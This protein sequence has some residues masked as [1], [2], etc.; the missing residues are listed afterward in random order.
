MR[1]SG[2]LSKPALGLQEKHVP[3]KMSSRRFSQPWFNRTVKRATGRNKRSFWKAIRINKT[4]DYERYYR[5]KKELWIACKSAYNS[6]IKNIISPDSTSNPKRFWG[7]IKGMRTDATGVAPLKDSIGLTHLDSNK[8]ANILYEQFSSVFN[9]D[10]SIDTI[11]GKG[12]S[13]Y[14]DMP[15]ISVGREGRRKL[16][17]NPQI[18]QATGPDGVT[19][20][21]K[22][23]LCSNIMAHVERNNL[24]HD[25]QHGF[26]KRRSRESQLIVTFKDLAH[27]IDTKGQTDVIL[28]DFSKAFDKAPTNVFCTSSTT[29]G[30][31]T[32]DG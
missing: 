28:L 4:K 5:L 9:K 15:H 13:P 6:N 7:F 2:V 22:H 29:T 24:L 27:N 14:M 10:E 26:R 23:I 1:R 21:L 17:S 19:C 16:L 20:R 30:T 12:P 32:S 11:H 3:S 18:H 25:A 31:A 8:K